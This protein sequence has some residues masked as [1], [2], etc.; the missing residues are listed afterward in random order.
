MKRRHDM[1]KK[2]FI[3]LI[4]YRAAFHNSHRYYLLP[5]RVPVCFTHL[6]Y[7]YYRIIPRQRLIPYRKLKKR[8]G[9][10]ENGHYREEMRW[11]NTMHNQ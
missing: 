7:N 6:L 8:W 10:L 9:K 1:N 5:S 2:S 11:Q 3:T 4:S